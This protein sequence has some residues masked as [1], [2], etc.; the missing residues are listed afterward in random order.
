MVVR[1][2]DLMYP[3]VIMRVTI[4][5]EY[6][7]E[8]EDER[9]RAVYPEGIHGCLASRL[10]ENEGWEVRTAT[11]DEPEN[12]LPQSRIDTSDVLIW[13]GHMAHGE[14]APETVGRVH[15][16]VLR[17]MGFIALHSAHFSQPF[18][19]LMGTSCALTWREDGLHERLW[20]VDATHPIAAGIDRY[21]EIPQTEMYGEFFDVPQP[22]ELV[23]I[24]WY[25]GGEVMRSGMVWKRGRGRVF[26]FGP[27]HETFPIYHQPQVQTVIENACRYLA[28]GPRATVTGIIDA[29]NAPVSPEETRE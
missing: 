7:H 21:L 29:P 28:P 3:A 20:V 16:A 4:W 5:N 25:A 22:D 27:G 19:R 24:S 15:E 14:V 17:G 8:R 23:F 10:A 18:R 2:A 12:G 11:L 13:W 6:R 1:A 26:Y 9:V